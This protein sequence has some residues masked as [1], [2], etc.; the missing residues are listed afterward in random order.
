MISMRKSYAE[1]R[2]HPD[3]PSARDRL[4]IYETRQ[5]RDM[6]IL[7]HGDLDIIPQH[8]ILI[9][10]R[11]EDVRDKYDRHGRMRQKY[12]RDHGWTE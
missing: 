6:S 3:K 1:L 8:D 11:Y 9:P 2:V 10:V 5:E 12:K 7:R 4:L